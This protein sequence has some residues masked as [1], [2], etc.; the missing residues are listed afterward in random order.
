MQAQIAVGIVVGIV[1]DQISA[2]AVGKCPAIFAGQDNAVAVGVGVGRFAA[3]GFGAGFGD[4]VLILL[5]A[6]VLLALGVA[7]GVSAVGLRF[8]GRSC[9]SAATVSR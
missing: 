3:G 6:L 2:V 1:G 5:I 8:G 7:D 4:V 9:A